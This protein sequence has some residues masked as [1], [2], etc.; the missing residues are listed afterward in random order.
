MFK[1][2]P[3]T[4]T[5]IFSSD[6]TGYGKRGTSNLAK[7]ARIRAK[8]DNYAVHLYEQAITLK[9]NAWIG[10]SFQCIRALR[11]MRE[12]MGKMVYAEAAPGRR[13]RIP[14][15]YLRALLTFEKM[16]Q[17]PASSSETDK[18][19]LKFMVLKEIRE[20]RRDIENFRFSV[21]DPTLYGVNLNEDLLHLRNGAAHKSYQYNDVDYEPLN[22]LKAYTERNRNADR[23]IVLEQNTGTDR[24]DARERAM[25]EKCRKWRARDIMIN[26]SP[27]TCQSSSERGTPTQ[28]V[29]GDDSEE[30]SPGHSP[31]EGRE[32]YENWTL[33]DLR[34]AKQWGTERIPVG[35]A[36]NVAHGD[37][38][39]TTQEMLMESSDSG[40][41]ETGRRMR[42]KR[43]TPDVSFTSSRQGES[44]REYVQ[45]AAESG[46]YRCD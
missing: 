20:N 28:Y 30:D 39:H 37:R 46:W 9:E 3:L 33:N 14:E 13:N 38:L 11:R 36:G 15:V 42:S 18:K 29:N 21:D 16:S 34:Q 6:P 1:R 12:I 22:K 41:R 44:E 35:G 23:R 25:I 40:R 24:V 7:S 27:E 2:K 10:I 26:R 45:G 32:K 31:K 8:M 19:K 43:G 5:D 4:D 17:E